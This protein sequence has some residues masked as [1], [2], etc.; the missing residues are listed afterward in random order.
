M[1]LRWIVVWL[2]LSSPAWAQVQP[3]P[4]V[5]TAPFAS[6]EGMT[7]HELAALIAERDRQYAQRF[8]AQQKAVDAALTA[9]DKA[10]AAAF[11]AAEKAVAAALAAQEK[12]TSAA[13]SAASEAV[14]TAQQ[15]NEKRLD[16]VNEF[17]KQL[18]DQ[19]AT[20]ATRTEV[21]VQF[22]ALADKLEEQGKLVTEM[23]ARS[24]GAATLW[25]AAIAVMMLLIGAVTV[26]L[27]MFRRAR[28][29]PEDSLETR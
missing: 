15:A 21:A 20:L 12:A 24:E 14:K 1:R 22:K 23:R 25:A 9:Q 17:R 8:E 10:T 16:S 11:S 18:K 27:L 2:A 5:Q 4:P 7:L 3:L 19:T 29:P 6:V 13:F 26:G 28:H